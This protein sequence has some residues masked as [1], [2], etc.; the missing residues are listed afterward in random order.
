MRDFHSVVHQAILHIWVQVSC[1]RNRF[2][3]AIC[4]CLFL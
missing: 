4:C 2:R 1:D 3:I